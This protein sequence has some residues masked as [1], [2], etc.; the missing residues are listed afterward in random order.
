MEING[1]MGC[2]WHVSTQFDQIKYKFKS[3]LP[4]NT[5]IHTGLLSNIYSHSDGYTLSWVSLVHEL[6]RL[7][8]INQLSFLLIRFT[9]WPT[10][11]SNKCSV[12][13][14]IGNAPPKWFI[15]LNR[16]TMSANVLKNSKQSQFKNIKNIYIF[17]SVTDI[18][19][20]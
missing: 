10:A 18:L 13:G 17:S 3:H 15:A 16:M 14:E 1:W 7:E 5:H 20:Q 6:E 11:G 12:M 9:T 4:N 8:E 19:E 2:Y